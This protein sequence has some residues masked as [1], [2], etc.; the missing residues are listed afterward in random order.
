MNEHNPFKEDCHPTYTDLPVEI[1]TKILLYLKPSNI[2]VVQNVCPLWFNII[3][4][5]VSD[6][7]IKSDMYVS[8]IK[9]LKFCTLYH[10]KQLNPIV[11]IVIPICVFYLIYRNFGDLLKILKKTTQRSKWKV[12]KFHLIAN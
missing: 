1:W 12:L 11:K 6:G 4:N 7:L 10:L 5:F 8:T 2:I 3:Q 9:G